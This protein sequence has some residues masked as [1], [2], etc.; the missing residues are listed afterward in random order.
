MSLRSKKIILLVILLVVVL[1]ANARE[2]VDWLDHLG[3]IAWAQHVRSEYVT[4][5][6]IAVIL[7]MVFLLG[8]T[9][10]I[11]R[12]VRILRRC[13]VCDH[14]FFR[15]AKYCGACGSRMA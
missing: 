11:A 6:S 14:T 9:Q 3:V 7:A 5:T 8:G 15:P 2:V 12:C 1:S 13:S 10:M 4:G